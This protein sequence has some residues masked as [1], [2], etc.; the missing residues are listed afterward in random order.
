M[1]VLGM[2]LLVLGAVIAVSEAHFPTHGIAGGLGVL[3]MAVGA[4]LAVSGLGAGLLLALLAGGALAGSGAALLTVTVKQGLLVRRRQVR[5]GAQGLIGHVGVVRN[6]TGEAGN[7]AL[8]GALWH[9]RES[10]AA[11]EPA[12]TLHAGDP[13]VV[14]RLNGLTLCVRRAEEWELL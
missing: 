14:E 10:P 11:D 1:T 9:A 4:V 3:A 2:T 6:W 8:D 12:T 5:G 13:V 7:V